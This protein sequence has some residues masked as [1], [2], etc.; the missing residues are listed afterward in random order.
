[1]SIMWMKKHA[2]WVIVGAALLVGVSLIFMD[3]QGAYRSGF[4][5][6]YVGGVD[7]EEIQI[8]AF[9][10]DLKNYIR[11]EEVRTGKAPEGAQ[12]A[13]IR[14]NLF[15][16]KVLSAIIQKKFKAYQLYPSVEEMQE[17]LVTHP[18]EVAASLAAAAPGK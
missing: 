7:G 3:R 12:L 5:G 2:K 16:M 1:M 18:K 9:Q 13:K 4:Q 17:Y 6:N 14:E 8:G 15:Q 11:N 10:Q